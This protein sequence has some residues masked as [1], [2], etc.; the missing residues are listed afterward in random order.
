MTNLLFLMPSPSLLTPSFSSLG[1]PS[2]IL[3]FEN[4]VWEVG[5]HTHPS[6]S[7]TPAGCPTIQLSANT[8]YLEIVS[9]LTV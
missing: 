7:Q 4:S 1:P 9:E 3:K 5:F 8:I 2:I 6:H